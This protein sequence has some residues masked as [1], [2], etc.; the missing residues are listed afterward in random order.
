MKGKIPQIKSVLLAVPDEGAVLAG[1]RVVVQHEEETLV[2]LEGGGVHLGELPGAVDELS[3]DGRHLLRVARDVADALAELVSERQPVLLDERL[4][5]LRGAVVG[6]QQ[7]RGQR[8]HLRRAVPAVRAVHH[9]AHAPL[10]GVRHEPRRVQHRLD[11]PQPAARLQPAQ[12]RVHVRV[13]Q[14]ACC[15]ITKLLYLGVTHTVIF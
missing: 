6:V 2:E 1:G 10:D 11:V 9:H 3:E 7:Q 5:A 15:N 12:E 14:L 4:V 13:R 8:A